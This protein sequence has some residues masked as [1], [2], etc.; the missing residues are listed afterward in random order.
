MC[1]KRVTVVKIC[2][3]EAELIAERGTFDKF[4]A[5]GR[6]AR[7]STRGRRAEF[8]ECLQKSR[9]EGARTACKD[10]RL[11]SDSSAELHRVTDFDPDDFETIL[12]RF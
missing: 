3:S 1:S 12:R 10:E 8:D 9:S 2:F 7:S 5:P 6:A 11:R 4:G